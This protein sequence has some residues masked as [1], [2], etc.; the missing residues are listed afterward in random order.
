MIDDKLAALPVTDLLHVCDE[1][2]TYR[3]V[4][5]ALEERLRYNRHNFHRW[6]ERNKI[7][8]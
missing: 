3:R 7:N 8:K 1:I 4:L 5:I 6:Y 2:N